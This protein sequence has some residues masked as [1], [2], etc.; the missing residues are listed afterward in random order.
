M[1]R[2]GN[3]LHAQTMHESQLGLLYGVL[4]GQWV[5]RLLPRLVI[6]SCHGSNMG[7]IGNGQMAMWIVTVTKCMFTITGW[8][9]STKVI[10][11]H[12]GQAAVRPAN[13]HTLPVLERV[14]ISGF[15]WWSPE[16]SQLIMFSLNGFYHSLVQKWWPV[17]TWCWRPLWRYWQIHSCEARVILIVYFLRD[18]L[19]IVNPIRLPLLFYEVP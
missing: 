12:S 7:I 19:D 14:S 8:G 2:I 18:L 5:P 16:S 6:V 17:T 11:G 15:A 9:W 1:R 10:K 4:N 13:K 3:G